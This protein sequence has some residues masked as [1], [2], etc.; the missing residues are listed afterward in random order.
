M[1]FVRQ[2]FGALASNS[3]KTAPDGT[4]LF[5]TGGP[6]ARPYVVPDAETE[7]RLLGKQRWVMAITLAPIFAGLPFLGRLPSALGFLGAI[8]AALIAS[9]LAHYFLVRPELGSL[10]RA[11]AGLSVKEFYGDTAA[12]HS[13]TKLVLFLV[14]MLVLLAAAIFALP[15]RADPIV[16]WLATGILGLVTL[17]YVYLIAVKLA[18]RTPPE[19]QAVTDQR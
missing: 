11:P 7:Q 8:A 17:M 6:W 12:R 16:T 5:Y 4:R 3:F 13:L 19:T 9:W 1:R 15:N 2:Y 10:T 14:M 18:T